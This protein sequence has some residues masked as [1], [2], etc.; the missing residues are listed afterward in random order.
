M[1]PRGSLAFE[2]SSGQPVPR[3]WQ[4]VLHPRSEKI[5]A[6]PRIQFEQLDM[7]GDRSVRAV[8]RIRRT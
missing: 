4:L 6:T 5:A 1:V 3:N 8:P 2:V 7:G